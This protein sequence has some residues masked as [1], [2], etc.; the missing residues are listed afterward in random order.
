MSIEQQQ[1]SI[2]NAKQLLTQAQQEI[3]DAIKEW[4]ETKPVS[5]DELI[6][7]LLEIKQWFIQQAL[8]GVYS[9]NQ[10]LV[11]YDEALLKHLNAVYPLNLTRYDN[12]F[13]SLKFALHRTYE[14]EQGEEIIQIQPETPKNKI[15][16]QPQDWKE[17]WDVELID[18]E[19]LPPDS[20]ITPQT[21]SWTGRESH[22]IQRYDKLSLFADLAAKQWR[23]IVWK[24]KVWVKWNR[25]YP[26]Y[27]IH[28]ATPYQWTIYIKE[29][30]INP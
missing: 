24:P 9:K 28:I 2:P 14:E 6:D 17:P 4:I 19:I 1:S 5:L 29:T 16:V 20:G 21:W 25:P 30:M 22:E 27:A 18:Q 12:Q 13:Q 26:Y 7:Y 10:K 15:I 11:S 8:K 3:S 23:T